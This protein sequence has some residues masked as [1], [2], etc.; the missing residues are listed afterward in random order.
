M[1]DTYKRA[2]RKLR[3]STITKVLVNQKRVNVH[4]HMVKMTTDDSFK[5]ATGARNKKMEGK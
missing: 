5:R 4:E 2:H 3:L 1:E